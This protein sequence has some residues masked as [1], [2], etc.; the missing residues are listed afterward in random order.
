M[1]APA[2]WQAP[3]PGV[4]ARLLQP[5]GALYGAIVARRMKKPGARPGAPVIVV[6]NFVA[7][8][9]GKT[10]VALAIARLLEA[11]GERP[12]FLSRGYGGS[13]THN[14]ALRVDRQGAGEIGDEALLLA[15]VAPTF[16][17]RDR[18]AAAA[19]AVDDAG[20][21]VL[22][23]DDGLQSRQ[24]EPDLALA[25]VDGATGAGN[26]LCLPAG[27]LRAPLAAQL[28]HVHALVIVGAGAAGDA[29]AAQASGAG[30][31][32]LRVR[33]EPDARAHALA[34][35][36]VVAFAGI[37]LPDK[38]FRTLEE[39][40]ANVVERRAFPDHYPYRVSD[41]EELVATARER[42]ARLVTTQ[43]DA[44]RLP[45]LPDGAQGPLAIPVRIVF[46]DEAAARA[47]LADALARARPWT[48]QV[49]VPSPLAGE[50]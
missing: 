25:V 12:A 17:G 18:A 5:L 7:G 43:K 28:V 40:G 13:A 45:P 20:P 6:G 1:R 16:V 30:I 29:I 50:G 36:A 15:Q 26:G 19:L 33:L 10:P 49:V 32:I 11:Q 23:L 22:I 9:A 44:V 21:S 48:R 39:I 3:R 34:G 41:I 35:Q 2:F 37:G 38:F 8:G 27:P 46:E 24:V 14:G 47:L 42:G 31:K 4:A